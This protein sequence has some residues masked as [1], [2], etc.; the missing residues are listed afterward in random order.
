MESQQNQ[1]LSQSEAIDPKADSFSYQLELLKIELQSIDQAIWRLI[2][3]TQTTKNWAIVTWAG[4]IAI[5]VSQ[6]PE[7][8]KYIGFTAALPLLFWYVDAYW[9]YIQ[10]RYDF[11]ALK[12]HQ[13]LND[14]RLVKS[15]EQKKLMGL[16]VYDPTGR[17]YAHT[18]E[19]KKFT[20]IGR[21]LRFP[22]VM[23]FYLVLALISIALEI[24]F[25]LIPTVGSP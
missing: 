22:E 1:P 6:Q 3:V 25:L 18:E 7:F 23:W 20:S 12:I 17:Q 14:D 11:R 8:R 16:T 13:F 2:E 9:R 15:F 19:L 21:T 10:R 4:S 24:F 5:V